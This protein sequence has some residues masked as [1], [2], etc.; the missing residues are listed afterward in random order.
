M[1]YTN[2]DHR[3]DTQSRSNTS[4]AILQK[5]RYKLVKESIDVVIACHPKDMRTLDLAIH[6]I[7]TYGQ[8]VRHVYVVSQH[9]LTTRATWIPEEKYPFTKQMVAE[10]IFNGDTLRAKE[11]VEAPGSRIGWIYQQLLKLYA[12]L[13]IPNISSNVLILDAD[14]IFLRPTSFM[15]DAAEPLFNQTNKLLYAPYFSHAKRLIP[16]LTRVFP[17][18]S[19]IAHHMLFQREIIKDFMFII[20]DLH[21]KPAWMA[22]CACID[23]NDVPYSCMS[24]YELYFNFVLHKSNIAHLRTLKN[25]NISF[26]QYI[27]APHLFQK[28]DYVSCHAWQDKR[29]HDNNELWNSNQSSED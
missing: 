25:Q 23:K 26:S 21:H 18:T 9:P 13:V 28:Y 20:E 17:Q 10:A 24:E 29:S 3:Y 5:K 4:H 15:T 12:P 2:K 1:E 27:K 11:F 14:T 6:G 22:I 19:G 8:N 7:K 16:W